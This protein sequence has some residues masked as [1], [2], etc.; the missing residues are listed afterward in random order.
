MAPPEPM[1]ARPE[2]FN[3][4]KDKTNFMKMIEILKGK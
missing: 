2:Y 1:T 4:L 3:P